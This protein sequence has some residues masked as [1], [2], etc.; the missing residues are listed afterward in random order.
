M[1]VPSSDDEPAHAAEIQR[2]DSLKAKAKKKKQKRRN[3]IT[4]DIS[5]RLQLTLGA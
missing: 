5:R 4:F 3:P 2:H 1:S